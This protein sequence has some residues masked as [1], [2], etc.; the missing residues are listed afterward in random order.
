MDT[1]TM[2][3]A[4][5]LEQAMQNLLVSADTSATINN[6]TESPTTITSHNI[7][8]SNYDLSHTEH[9]QAYTILGETVIKTNHNPYDLKSV[10]VQ[11]DDGA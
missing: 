7:S 5:V 2:K 6:E 9:N 11:D 3:H 8:R 1:S 10:I 4:S